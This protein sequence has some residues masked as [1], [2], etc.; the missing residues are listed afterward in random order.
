MTV[1]TNVPIVNIISIDVSIKNR[2]TDISTTIPRDSDTIYTF[3]PNTKYKLKSL[4]HDDLIAKITTDATGKIKKFKNYRKQHHIEYAVIN[5]ID[6][7]FVCKRRDHQY[8]KSI[9][10]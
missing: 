2:T 9:K 3:A 5:Q 4:K 1:G 7:L 10:V 8:I 6:S